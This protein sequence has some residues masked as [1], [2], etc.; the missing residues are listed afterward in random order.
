[1]GSTSRPPEPRNCS[2]A[3]PKS[4]V[5]SP[6]RYSSGSTSV[7]AELAQVHLYY[8]V[9]MLRG[10]GTENRKATHRAAGHRAAQSCQTAESFLHG[11]HRG[12]ADARPRPQRF[13]DGATKCGA[14]SRG[15]L[16]WRL[17][18]GMEGTQPRPV[19]ASGGNRQ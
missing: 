16:G 2:R 18:H 8:E 4:P 17:H 12:R 10:G 7:I 1:M 3:A 5:E 13:L 6:C 9:A 14:L 19:E 15:C 11:L